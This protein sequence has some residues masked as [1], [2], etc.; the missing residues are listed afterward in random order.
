MHGRGVDNEH[1]TAWPMGPWPCELLLVE[2]RW[3]RPWLRGT[4]PAPDVLILTEGITD[5]WTS[6]ITHP[7]IG[8]ASGSVP[9]LKLLRI[10][11]STKV[12]SAMDPDA[13]GARYDGGIADA[14]WPTPVRPLPLRRL[15][16]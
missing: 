3:A 11:S 10:P 8:L 7:T 4:G 13:A 15:V 2:P 14:L 12:F 1:K 16:A 5:F 6:S 9:A